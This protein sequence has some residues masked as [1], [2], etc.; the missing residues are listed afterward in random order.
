[1]KTRFAENTTKTISVFFILTILICAVIFLYVWWDLQRFKES[2]WEMS[3]TSP[4]IHLQKE[5][6]TN[7]YIELEPL[8]LEME[9]EAPSLETLDSLIDGLFLSKTESSEEKTTYVQRESVEKT[10]GVQADQFQVRR[11]SKS[12]FT[13]LESG[14]F[15]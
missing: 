10:E 8:G 15:R 14:S 4:I 9:I 6:M 5:S 11:D 1:M 12:S 2:L 7:I 13:S 3:V